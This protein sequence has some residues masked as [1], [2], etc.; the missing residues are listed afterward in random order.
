MLLRFCPQA[1]SPS[2]PLGLCSLCPTHERQRPMACKLSSCFWP[3]GLFSCPTQ[4]LPH[5][6]TSG[7]PSPLSTIRIHYLD[8]LS[9]HLMHNC[10][11]TSAC[12]LCPVVNVHLFFVFFLNWL[13]FM[14]SISPVCY[15][16]RALSSCRWLWPVQC[17]QRYVQRGLL[18]FWQPALHLCPHWYSPLSSSLSND[19]VSVLLFCFSPLCLTQCLSAGN[20]HTRP[21]FTC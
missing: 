11:H 2:G 7:T 6:S 3:L 9:C 1:C 4:D 5:R 12:V 13:L 16:G 19:T 15:C 8:C 10:F 14:L 17:F 18:W 21:V 20:R